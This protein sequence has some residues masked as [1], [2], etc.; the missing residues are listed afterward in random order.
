MR[1][2]FSSSMEAN[3]IFSFAYALL[4]K[5]LGIIDLDADGG[6]LTQVIVN[7]ALL[8]ITI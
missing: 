7:S 3:V 4:E 1:R 2:H 6:A 8:F 5:F